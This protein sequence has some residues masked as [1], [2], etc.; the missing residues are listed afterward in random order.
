MSLFPYIFVSPY[1]CHEV[2]GPDA[3]IFIFWML[4]FKPI[5]LLSSFIFIRRLFSSSSL[6]L[7]MVVLSAYLRLLIFLPAILI[8][9]VLQVCC[10]MS[11]SNCCFWTCILISQEAGKVV[12]YS[13]LFNNFPQFVMEIQNLWECYTTI[14]NVFGIKNI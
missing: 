3:M 13:H 7:I 5:F 14:Q 2:M 9:L 11:G 1:I 4:S 6:S 12:W 10:S 8:Q